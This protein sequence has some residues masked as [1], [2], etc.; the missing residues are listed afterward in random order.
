[1]NAETRNIL[2]AARDR[3]VDSQSVADAVEARLEAEVLLCHVL[4]V[5]RAALYA[6]P[7]QPLGASTAALFRSLVARRLNGEPVAYIIGT[8][9]FYGLTFRV[10]P[11]VLIPRPETEL[12]V[13]RALAAA[14]RMARPAIADV[15]CGSGCVGIAL[16]AHLPR[17]SVWAI[18]LCEGALVVTN[19][20]AARLGVGSRVT[21]LQGDLLGP[22]PAPV[23][24]IVANL[25]YVNTRDLAELAPS[26]VKF[27]PLLALSGGITGLDQIRRLVDQSPPH[28]RPGGSLLL[29]VGYDQGDAVADLVRARFAGASV[30]SWRDLGGHVRV[31]GVQLAAPEGRGPQTG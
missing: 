21:T 23:D 12:L 16:A 20:N 1:M 22:L 13:E 2:Q 18:D 15:G 28:L 3:L 30:E 14:S 7:T 25:P 5:D 27:E 31:V 11:G 6:G 29:E 24:L 19:E 9:D 4:G 8:R 10:G 17:A 26:I